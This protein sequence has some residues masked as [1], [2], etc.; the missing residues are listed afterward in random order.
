MMRTRHAG[1]NRDACHGSAIVE[2]AVILSLGML[3][4]AVITDASAAWRV[5][6]VLQAAVRE[7]ARVAS[8]TPGLQV[9]DANVLGV[10]DNVAQQ[11]WPDLFDCLTLHTCTRT[12]SF[13]LP[14]NAGDPVT[15]KFVFDYKPV[16]LGVIPSEH[17]T[18][19]LT[20]SST[21]RYEAR[22]NPP[23]FKQLPPAGAQQLP[24]T[25]PEQLPPAAPE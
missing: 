2:V 25:E 15:V 11:S 13:A 23:N 14:L 6:Q 19:R 12:V 5:K 21:M 9:N 20:S 3:L 7:G 18:I 10:V 8:G 4:M 1:H 16:I 22:A 24:L 17:S